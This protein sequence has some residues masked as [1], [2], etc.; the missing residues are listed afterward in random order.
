MST[1]LLVDT[2]T[3]IDLISTTTATTTIIIAAAAATAVRL[4]V[5]MHH[6]L[7]LHSERALVLLEGG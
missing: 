7:Q 4:H 1:L 6:T 2:N 5:Y 3:I